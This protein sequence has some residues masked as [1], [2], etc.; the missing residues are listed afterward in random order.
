[1][2]QRTNIQR[3]MAV[4]SSDGVQVGRVVDVAM[5]ALIVEKGRFFLQD[6]RVPFEDIA[7]CLGDE[8]VL[9]RDHA[10]LRRMDAAR[11]DSARFQDHEQYELRPTGEAVAPSIPPPHEPAMSERRA[12]GPGWDPLSVD[13]EPAEAPRKIGPDDTEPPTRY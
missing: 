9:K 13:E 3:G 6:L 11:M 5:D 12:A 10:A 1:M 4:M 2:E 7:T 8:I